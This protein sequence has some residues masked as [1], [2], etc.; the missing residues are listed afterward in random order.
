MLNRHSVHHGTIGK[1]APERL[2]APPF[3]FPRESTNLS[4]SLLPFPSPPKTTYPYHLSST[5][6]SCSRGMSPAIT[7][8]RPFHSLNIDLFFIPPFRLLLTFS[9]SGLARTFGRATYA[10]PS[11]VARAFQPLR[12]SALPALSARFASSET[13]QAGKVHQVIG[14]VVD[15]TSLPTPLVDGRRENLFPRPNPSSKPSQ[16]IS[17]NSPG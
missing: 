17:I 10:R 11:P 3:P 5:P 1:T 13:A 6:P 15:G 8:R 9:S 16:S 4:S 2:R 7:T 12:S 14:A